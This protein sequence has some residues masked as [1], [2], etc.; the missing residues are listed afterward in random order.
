MVW[1]GR[2][3]GDDPLKIWREAFAASR[4][5]TIEA[6]V[7]MAREE[8]WRRMRARGYQV[9]SQGVAMQRPHAAGFN[10]PD[11]WVI[12]DWR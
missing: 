6:G 5:A 9:I 12:D 2:Q 4:G 7:N 1:R 11:A 3:L 8:A 10:R